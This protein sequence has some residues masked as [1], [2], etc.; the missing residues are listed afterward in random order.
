M[1]YMTR[2]ENDDGISLHV[3]YVVRADSPGAAS[4]RV[5]CAMV[6]RMCSDSGSVPKI[7]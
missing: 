5:T 3:Q 6:G 7:S 1:E 2:Y 4:S